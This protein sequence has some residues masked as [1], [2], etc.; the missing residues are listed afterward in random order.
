MNRPR[1]SKKQKEAVSERAKQCCEYCSS[2]LRFSP[3][4]FSVEHIVPISKEGTDNLDNL[5]LA[6]QGCNS[7]KYTA[8]SAVDPASGQEV[9]LFNPRQDNW[10]EH[11]IWSDDF[12]LVVGVT[13]TGRATI[14]KLQLN[15]VG[16]VN[17]RKVLTL[18]EEHPPK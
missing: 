12:S 1:L 11:F 8:T 10:H 4:P 7:R 5:A 9:T 17:L 2:Q 14:V 16:V 13:P 6:C 18:Q 3:D 15:R